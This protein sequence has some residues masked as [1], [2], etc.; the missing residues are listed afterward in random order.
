MYRTIEV[1]V[2]VQKETGSASKYFVQSLPRQ[3]DNR[4]STISWRLDID[5]TFDICSGGSLL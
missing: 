3:A 4:P 2:S 5:S 1:N